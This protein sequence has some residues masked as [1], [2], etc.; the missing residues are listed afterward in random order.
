M[1]PHN[2]LHFDLTTLPIAVGDLAFGQ[3]IHH[4]EDHQKG[5]SQESDQEGRQEGSSQE[6]D[7][8]DRQ[9]GSSQEGD[10]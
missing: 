5:S 8:E 10:S 1:I 3:T 2:S 6:G 9:E 4:Q 7:Q